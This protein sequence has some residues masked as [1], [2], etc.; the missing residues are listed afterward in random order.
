MKT[1]RNLLFFFVGFFFSA[2]AVLSFAET[3]PGTQVTSQPM[4]SSGWTT[5]GGYSCT[6]SFPCASSPQA[7]ADVICA[8]YNNGSTA[9]ITLVNAD[10]Y[11]VV[12]SKGGGSST[13]NAWDG[14]P[15]GWTNNWNTQPYSCTGSGYTCPPGVGYTLNGTSCTRPDC[16]PGQTR[17]Q[18]GV[19]ITPCPAAGASGSGVGVS[20]AYS[21]S[22]AF[23]ENGLCINGC[24]YDWGGV[25]VGTSSGWAASAGKSKGQSCTAANPTKIDTASP[26][27]KCINSGQSFGTVNGV[28]VCTQ[29]TEVK[30]QNTTTTKTPVTTTDP[31]APTPTGTNVE[32]STSCSGDTCT[33][34]K[35]TTSPA[36]AGGSQTTKE[37]TTQSKADYCTANPKAV[38]CSGQEQEDYCKKHPDSV[39]CLEAGTPNEEGALPTVDKSLI[40]SITPVSV[41]GSGSCPAPLSLPKGLS[42][43]FQPTCDFVSALKPIVLISAWLISGLI[44]F[45]MART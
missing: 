11:N 34:T 40:S 23:P 26:A 3:I 7:A 2:Y 1:L 18:N 22:G 12:C 10:T 15:S 8:R 41:G 39:G 35:S 4:T 42:Y 31:N 28:V 25:G 20:G 32:S 38:Q 19:C 37:E 43:S 45:G 36:A 13:M 6:T 17:D 27:E 5:N 21:G 16:S 24:L 9:T 33:T 30:K 44:V 14:C 29:P